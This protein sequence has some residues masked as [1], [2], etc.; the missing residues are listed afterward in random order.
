[1]SDNRD[2]NA[3]K[4]SG[5]AKNKNDFRLHYEKA[6]NPSQ[7]EAVTCTEGPL[8]VIAG[9]GS[10]GWPISLKKAYRRPLFFF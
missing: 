1:M 8:L 7:L 4:Q 10:G 9:A 5:A 3:K 6:L 2:H